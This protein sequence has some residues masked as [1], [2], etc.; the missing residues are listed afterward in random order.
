MIDIKISHE[1]F[2]TIV[3]G[4]EKYEKMKEGIR[5]IKSSYELNKENGKTT[6]I[7]VKILGIHKIK[8]MFFWYV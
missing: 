7:W 3:N 2:K 5:M 8:K 4:K 1:E 6:Q